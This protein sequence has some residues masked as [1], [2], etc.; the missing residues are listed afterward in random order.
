MKILCTILVA[1]C[2]VSCDGNFIYSYSSKKQVFEFKAP[3]DSAR[4]IFVAPR[5]MAVGTYTIHYKAHWNDSFI[6]RGKIVP[7]SQYD[8]KSTNE[9]YGD[10]NKF[11]YKKYKAT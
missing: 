5:D 3:Q 11:W 10:T 1:I 4:A 9:F 7:P 2:L 8:S 6:D